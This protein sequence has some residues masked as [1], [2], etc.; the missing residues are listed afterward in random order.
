LHWAAVSDN[1]Y[2]H[3]NRPEEWLPANLL[4]APAL[5][6]VT[7]QDAG[8]RLAEAVKVETTEGSRTRKQPT[9]NGMST[10]NSKGPE[11]RVAPAACDVTVWVTLKTIYDDA[12]TDFT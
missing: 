3:V 2:G 12:W 1:K 6:Q 4:V 9:S 10:N 8:V 11:Y 5:R 7:M